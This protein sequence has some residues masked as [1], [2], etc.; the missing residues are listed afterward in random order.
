M[1]PFIKWVLL[2]A[3]VGLV[4]ITAG[5]VYEQWAAARDR[6]QFPPPGELVDVGDVTLHVD[7]RGTG[8]PAVVLEAGLGMDSTGW[9]KV[10]DDLARLTRT[11]AYDRAGRGWSSP[12]SA[13]ISSELVNRRLRALLEAKV[14]DPV[15][16]V[17]MSAGGVFVRDYYARHPRHVV[18][19]VLVDSSHED[20]RHR[21]PEFPESADRTGQIRLCAWFQPVGVVRLASLLD[22]FFTN[23][24]MP[25]DLMAAALANAYQP[26][27]CRALLLESEGF[28]AMLV[29][30]GV[31]PALGDLPLVVLSQGKAPEAAPDVG[32]TVEMAIEQQAAWSVLQEELAALSSRGRRV[33]APEAGHLIQIDQPEAIVDAIRDLVTSLRA[34]GQVQQG[35]RGIR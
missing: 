7:C 15:I 2:P 24:G 14:R 6:A 21:L 12:G 34:A 16:L 18:G 8:T 25:D 27:F 11:C 1:N 33:V 30:G 10:H 23:A 29:A 17:G 3:F 20:Q 13:P 22:P 32:I 28:E 19:M 4:L 9:F 31:P 35:D 26:H 5:A